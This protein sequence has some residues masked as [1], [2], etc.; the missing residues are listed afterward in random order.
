MALQRQDTVN[1]K[2]CKALI[3]PPPPLSYV[4]FVLG[5]DTND[6]LPS[7]NGAEFCGGGQPLRPLNHVLRAFSLLRRPIYTI[8]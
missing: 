7:N 5:C 6:R 8:V 1:E 2:D 3:T 4:L